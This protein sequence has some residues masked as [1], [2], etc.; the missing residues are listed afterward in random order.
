MTRGLQLR[1][2][3]CGGLPSVLRQVLAALRLLRNCVAFAD[4]RAAN[5]LSAV[6]L[7]TTHVAESAFAGRRPKPLMASPRLALPLVPPVSASPALT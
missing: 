1:E 5:T 3:I 6:T 7:A 2:A 4:K